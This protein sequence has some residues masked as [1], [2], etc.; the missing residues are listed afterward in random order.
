MERAD[1]H[2][3]PMEISRLEQMAKAA[4]IMD[5]HDKEDEDGDEGSGA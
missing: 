4:E 5:E 3:D 1:E 2:L